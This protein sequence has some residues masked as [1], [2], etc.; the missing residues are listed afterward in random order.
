MS[1][2]STTTTVTVDRQSCRRSSSLRL[3]SP[4]YPFSSS[5]PFSTQ[6]WVTL[7][8][9]SSMGLSLSFF[10]SYISQRILMLRRISFHKTRR[11]LI[12]W[13]QNHDG[14]RLYDY[15]STVCICKIEHYMHNTHIHN[16]FMQQHWSLLAD[17][18]TILWCIV[19]LFIWIN[20]FLWG[21]THFMTHSAVTQR[22]ENGRRNYQWLWPLNWMCFRNTITPSC[23]DPQAGY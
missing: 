1:F 2:P 18:S 19:L 6:P 5:G 9:S 17:Y 15:I 3:L 21:F 23:F 16:T 14:R 4:P 8:L 11:F 20:V 22:C 10:L 13:Y 7:S 12:C